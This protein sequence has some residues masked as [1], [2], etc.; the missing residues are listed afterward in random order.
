MD[1]YNIINAAWLGTV[2]IA[3]GI[4]VQI[5]KDS[6]VPRRYA[7]LLAFGVGL[8]LGLLGMIP[9]VA[10]DPLTAVFTGIAAGG[11]AAGVYSGGKAI[12]QSS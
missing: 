12:V 9:P 2:G 4:I 7:G 10:L 6:I 5:L 3:T 11:V 8:A 1:T